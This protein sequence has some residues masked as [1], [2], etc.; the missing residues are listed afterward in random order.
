MRITRFSGRSLLLASLGLSHTWAQQV[1]PTNLKF[2]VASV[3]PHAFVQGDRQDFTISGNSVK[4]SVAPLY[5]LVR[6]AYDVKMDRISGGPAWASRVRD[7]A[8][9]IEAKAEGTPTTSQVRLMLQQ[10]L[11]ERFHLK[12]HR[13]SREIPIYQ[14]VIAKGSSKLA[15]SAPSASDKVHVGTRVA[16]PGVIARELSSDKMPMANLADFIASSAGRPVVDR[17]GL[18][19]AY[20]LWLSWTDDSRVAG[21]QATGEVPGPSI[22]TA[23]EEQLGLKLEPGRGPGEFLIIDSVEKPSEN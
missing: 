2:E 1:P 10:L 21:N 7:A 4:F 18:T 14:L 23:L 6:E 11:A 13:E 8:F 3:K 9:D 12:A 16:S 22:F 19:G 5:A 17:T 20:A 15:Q